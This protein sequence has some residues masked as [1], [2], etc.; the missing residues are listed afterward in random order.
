[1]PFGSKAA[2]TKDGSPGEVIDFDRIFSEVIEPAARAAG[3]AANRED[4]QPES[5][6]IHR[7]MIDHIL[8]ADI[9]IADATIRNPNVFYE[10]GVRH[11][12]RPSG[13]IIIRRRRGDDVPFDIQGMAYIEYVTDPSDPDFKA[14]QRAIST[15]I[16]AAL[17]SRRTDSLVHSLIPGLN[18]SLRSEIIPERKISE[19][20]LRI[21]PSD[22]IDESLA[23]RGVGPLFPA[24][25]VA[26]NGV[27]RAVT[28]YIGVITGDLVYVEDV[29]IWVNPES[30]RMEMGRVH[31]GA[32]EAATLIPAALGRVNTN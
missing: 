25:A 29:D 13:T 7:R 2:S 19:A 26:G 12:A 24:T 23:A 27:K 32:R 9:V 11:T 31:D 18:V 1:M 8:R 14:R 21:E 4:S 30:T 10:L 16:T 20:R 6:L 17:N 22:T 5:G 15:A 3:V 28:K